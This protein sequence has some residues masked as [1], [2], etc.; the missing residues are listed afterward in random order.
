MHYNNYI[1][2]FLVDPAETLPGPTVP[3]PVTSPACE[4]FTNQPISGMY[5][6]VFIVIKNYFI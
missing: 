1:F 3:E 5:I 6:I 4:T 2:L